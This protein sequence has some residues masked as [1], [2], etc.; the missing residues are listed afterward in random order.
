MTAAKA[1]IGVIEDDPALQ[2]LLVEELEAEGYKVMAWGS[3]EAFKKSVTPLD[4]V[5]SD[6]RLPGLSGLSLLESL[7]NEDNSPALLLITAFGTVDQAVDALKQG[8][9]DFLTKPLDVEH[10][11]LS[12]KRIL[13]HRSL[14]RELKRY[15][16]QQKGPGG[17][18]GQSPSMRKLYDQIERIA[19]ADGSVLITGESGTGK[20]LVAKAL[21]QLSDRAEQSFQAVN[22]AGIP[23]DLMESEFF[24]HAAGAFTGAQ[25]KR[26]GLLK[27]ADGGTL[28]LDEIGE[29][30][31]ALQAKLLRVLQEGTIRAVGS[32]EEETV[33]VRILAATHQDLEQQVEDGRFRQDLFYRLETFSLRVPPLRE[34]GEDIE[35]L[36]NYFL[37]QLQK[38]SDKTV[39]SISP[40]A[41]EQLYSYRFPGNV[42]ELQNAIERA[43]T[44]SRDDKIAVE[45]L[46]QRILDSEHEPDV[47]YGTEWPTLD[48]YQNQYICKVLAH[49]EGNKSKAAEILG[50]TRRTLYRWLEQHGE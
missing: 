30:P 33:N 16:Q 40:A 4:L 1:M 42:R 17:L 21:H 27:Q 46:P 9:D 25:K 28:L 15:R 12:V 11:L 43:F 35:R 23:A 13:E 26:Q 48:E 3:V 39:R 14:Q 6:I 10:L 32:D 2:E 44:F 37:Q 34:R 36:A 38:N 41:L 22:C 8:A 20:E 29:M 47:E 18:V 45:D 50:V 31:M 49:A 19:P 5:I 24:G 7:K